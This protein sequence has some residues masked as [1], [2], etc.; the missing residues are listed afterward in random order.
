MPVR[1]LSDTVA[2]RIAAGE[3][4]ERPA[5]VVKELAENALDAGAARIEIVL[6]GGGARLIRVSDD[7][8][9]MDRDDLVM[10][11]ERFATSKISSDEDLVGVATMGFRGEALPSIGAVARLAIA[12]RRRDAPHGWRLSVEGGR[13]G[14]AEPAAL[15]PGTRIE[16]RD[17]FF[18]TPARAKFLKSDRAEAQA[19][20][21]AVRRMALAAPHVDFTLVVEERTLRFPAAAPGAEGYAERLAQVLGAET[22]A[23]MIA[24]DGQREGARLVGHVG[25]SHLHRA[26]AGAIHLSVNGRPVRDRLL[27][28]ALKAAYQ[29]VMPRDRHPVAALDIRVGPG[30]VDVN[31]HPAKA[32]VRFRDSGLIRALVV[33]TV[34]AALAGAG[35]TPYAAGSAEIARFA[36]RTAPAAAWRPAAAPAPVWRPAA[37]PARGLAQPGQSAFSVDLMDLPP[38]ADPR[39]ADAAPDEARDRPLGAA[40]AHLHDTYVLAETADG[41][42]LVD[43]HA[44]H[45]RLV[46]EEL[47]RLRAASGVPRQELLVPDVVELDPADAERV[48][49][50]AP[51]LDGLGLGLEAFGPGA[52]LVRATPAPLGPCDGAALVRDIAET[53][54]EGDGEAGPVAR[55][56]DHILATV[57][58]HGSV[59]AGRKLKP[60]EMNALLRAIEAEPAASTCNHGRPTFVRL[61]TADLEKLFGRR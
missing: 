14:E 55:R 8:C 49:A 50:A 4:V 12:T 15:P 10:A 22:A 33:S 2:N 45:E 1:L 46:Y 3:V 53:L 59:R 40:K 11:V 21:E 39:V 20:A 41:V 38:I 5:S 6:E 13:K 58:C 52:L 48:L 30:E 16:V 37:T 54:A 35:P 42:V 32:E 17:L 23:A 9:G 44:A 26:T 47:K 61:S 60:D 43:A 56:L 51:L 24:I 7:G 25:Q 29:D 57:A 27:T 18:A 36:T 31:V 28:G 34:R 19:A